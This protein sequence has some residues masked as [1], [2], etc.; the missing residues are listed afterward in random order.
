M[1]LRTKHALAASRSL[2]IVSCPIGPSGRLA[3]NLAA[4]GPER[5]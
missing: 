5:R 1:D 2:R 3:A 4:E